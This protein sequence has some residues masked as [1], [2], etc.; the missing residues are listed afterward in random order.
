MRPTI[1]IFVHDRNRLGHEYD[2]DHDRFERNRRLN[3]HTMTVRRNRKHNIF[4]HEQL[5]ML[6]T[7]NHLVP[8]GGNY[9]RLWSSQIK[10]ETNNMDVAYSIHGSV[11]RAVMPMDRLSLRGCPVVQP[12]SYPEQHSCLLGACNRYAVEHFLAHTKISKEFSKICKDAVKVLTSAVSSWLW[13]V[14]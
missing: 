7:S 4:I 3:K 11:L 9:M 6:L 2:Q 8:T 1:L 14:K 12:F 13:M 5:V 10:M